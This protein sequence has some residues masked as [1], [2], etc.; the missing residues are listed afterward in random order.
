MTSFRGEEAQMMGVGAFG[1]VRQGR[2]GHLYQW[3]EGVDGLGN[4]IGFWKSL[5]KLARKAL[6]IARR[7]APFVP[8]GAAALTAASPFLK[9]AGVAGDD[10]VGL[11]QGPDGRLYQ[12]VRALPGGQGFAA[13]DDDVAGLGADEPSLGEIREGGDGRLYEWVEGIDGIGN[14]IGFWKSLKR[15]ARRAMPVVQRLAP[16][17]PGA[18]AALTVATPFL[19]QAG[20]AGYEGMAEPDAVEGL[21]EDEELRGLGSDDELHG[22]GDDEDLRGLGVEEE[23]RGCCADAGARAGQRNGVGRYVQEAAPGVA[24]AEPQGIPGEADAWKPIW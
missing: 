6:P 9:Q 20:V 19:K 8:G 17:V 11:Y 16:F 7:L 15:L 21:S 24:G 5:R 23:L 18:S 2:D 3:V 14:P 22:L 13:A 4:P 12:Q 1:E 10:G